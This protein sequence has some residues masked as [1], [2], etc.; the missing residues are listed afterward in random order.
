MAVATATVSGRL[1]SSACFMFL[2]SL[3]AVGQTVANGQVVP[4]NAVPPGQD[5]PG[6]QAEAAAGQGA[7]VSILQA[8]RPDY[9]AQGAHLGSFIL[10]PTL[11]V[12][13]TF[14]SNVYA[15]TFNNKSDFFTTLTPTVSVNSNWNR[16]FLGATVSGEIDRYSRYTSEDIDNFNGL[17]SGR[18]DILQGVYVNANGGYQILHEPRGSANSVNG[19]F[20]TE[21]HVAHGEVGFVK[22]NSILGFKLN[23]TID[24]YNYFDVPIS[25]GGVADET[26]RNRT[27]YEIVAQ[28]NYELTRQYH[29]FVR[30]SGNERDYDRKVDPTGFQRSSTGYQV[31]AGAALSI[32]SKV[33]GEF[34]VGYLS[35]NFDDPRFRTA[36]G[37][38]LGADLLWNITGITSIRG[39]LSRT[40]QETILPT[41]SSFIQTA[42]SVSVEH[43]LLRN[44]LLSASFNYANQDYQ[45]SPRVD[46]IYGVN[47]EAKYLLTR[48]LSTSVNIGYTKKVSNAAGDLDLA[49]YEQALAAVR[50]RLQF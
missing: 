29:A 11:D 16:D 45:D 33:D 37:L 12:S 14:T 47:V 32:A 23:A 10:L 15:E 30:A 34:Y 4:G 24:N 49:E 48:N 39:S 36:S 22:D 46:D 5:T 50:L 13:E 9:D 20:P 3:P 42:V 35:Q 31:D 8:P 2:I 43:E 25:S 41:A 18:L 19:E 26:Y 38:G 17:A 6:L 27:E 7:L 21:Y 1:W 40:V 44:V 28:A